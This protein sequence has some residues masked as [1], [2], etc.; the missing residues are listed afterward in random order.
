MNKNVVF[1]F[2]LGLMLFLTGCNFPT[3]DPAT[4]TVDE[5]AV[6][7]SVAG[8]LAVQIG[9]PEPLVPT[10][11][12]GEKVPFPTNTPGLSMTPSFTP[13]ITPSWTPSLTPSIT[14]SETSS[15]PRVS[16][17]ID[18]N[19][20]VGPGTGYEKVGA[21]LVGESADIVGRDETGNYWIIKN[22]DKAGTCWLWGEYASVSG[23]IS[24]LPEL[25]PPPSPT[26][27]P[28]ATP[29]LSFT[30]H[31]ENFHN[32]GGNDHITFYVGNT[33]SLPL[34]SADVGVVELATLA[35]VAD[36]FTDV[37]FVGTPNGCPP[38]LPSL[39]PGAVGYLPV[40]T[41]IPLNPGLHAAAVTIC[42]EDGMNGLCMVKEFNFTIP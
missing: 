33:G 8:T 19:C 36:G 15:V 38:E 35:A 25:T 18:T 16:V 14:P 29:A 3:G 9:E 42:T 41:N 21:L 17:T 23:N 34:E 2:T 26:P 13:S 30:I 5:N 31:Y 39:G 27:S 20:R 10:E 24:S 40:W 22:P 1:Y 28:T 7:T 11:T 32:C 6:R 12:V 37:P 4:P